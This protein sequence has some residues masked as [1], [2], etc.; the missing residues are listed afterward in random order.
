MTRPKLT[1]RDFRAGFAALTEPTDVGSG[2]L[3]KGTWFPGGHEC[4]ASEADEPTQL[5]CGCLVG[6]HDNTME[7]MRAA[8][9]EVIWMTDD[10]MAHYY[11]AFPKGVHVGTVLAERDEEIARL[12]RELAKARTESMPS[13]AGLVTTVAPEA[14]TSV[15]ANRQRQQNIDKVL[16]TAFPQRKGRS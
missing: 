15:I 14:H 11:A 1:V 4:V 5:G 3:L 2:A 6:E 13:V 16:H 12:K 10:G 7:A 8:H 9:P